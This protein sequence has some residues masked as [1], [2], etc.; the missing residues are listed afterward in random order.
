[1]NNLATQN[2][3]EGQV[4]VVAAAGAP[5]A[6]KPSK[7]KGYTVRDGDTPSI[8]AKKHNMELDEFLKLNNLTVKSKIYRGQVVKVKEK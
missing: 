2:L 4:L 5:V 1:M 3:K 8:I 7:P 6:E